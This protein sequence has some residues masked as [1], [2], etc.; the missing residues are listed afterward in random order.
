MQ[1]AS[2]PGVN[3]CHQEKEMVVKFH[4]VQA[5]WLPE[6]RSFKVRGRLIKH[7]RL[8]RSRLELHEW[9]KPIIIDRR[10]FRTNMEIKEKWKY[11]L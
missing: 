7:S 3:T 11:R 4:L 1:V 8:C 6:V 10:S 2:K 5:R 9:K